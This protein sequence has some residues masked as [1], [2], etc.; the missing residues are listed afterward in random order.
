MGAWGKG[1]FVN[2]VAYRDTLIEA[3]RGRCY[4]R[5]KIYKYDPRFVYSAERV[6]FVS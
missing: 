5:N 3:S 1:P 2:D 4:A 6:P